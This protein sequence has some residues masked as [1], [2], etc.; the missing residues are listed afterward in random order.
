[1]RRAVL[2]QILRTHAG[3]SADGDRFQAEE[4]LQ[5]DLL[6]T[7]GDEVI[8]LPNLREIT[9]SELYLGAATEKGETYFL[10]Y[11][12]VVGLRVK[13]RAEHRPGGRAGFSPV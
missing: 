10:E 7:A 13:P 12:H 1:M 9:L 3:V 2:D 6:A 4:H 11:E 8:T 5:V